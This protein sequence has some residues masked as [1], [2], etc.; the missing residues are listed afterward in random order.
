MEEVNIVDYTA[1]VFL[2]KE[3]SRVRGNISRKNNK[4]AKIEEDARSTRDQLAGAEQLRD[5]AI[6]LEEEVE[7][8]KEN[9]RANA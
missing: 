8:I 5:N 3:L 6:E 1:G 2:R 7:E 9:S 4:A